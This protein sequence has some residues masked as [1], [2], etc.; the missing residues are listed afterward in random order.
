MHKLIIAWHEKVT[1]IEKTAFIIG[2]ICSVLVI[3]FSVLQLTG[4][5]ENAINIT[6]PLLGV[7]ILSQG[8][9]QWKKNKIVSIFSFAVAAF[10]FCV[11]IY[12]FWIR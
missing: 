5:M 3:I 6:E 2:G 9:S 8:V 7:L 4:L 1:I 11:A 10:T 12:I